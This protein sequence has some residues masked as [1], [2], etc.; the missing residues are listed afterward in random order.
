MFSQKTTVKRVICRYLT[1]SGF[2]IDYSVYAIL[3]SKQSDVDISVGFT[4][5]LITPNSMTH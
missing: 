4:Y 3:F 1:V 2:R 5:S